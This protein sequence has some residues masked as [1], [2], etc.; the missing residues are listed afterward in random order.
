MV[1]HHKLLENILNINENVQYSHW[2]I[3]F[4]DKEI[5]KE[6]RKTQSSKIFWYCLAVLI[7]FYYL[8]GIIISFFNTFFKEFFIAVLILGILDTLATIVYFFIHKNHSRLKKLIEFSKICAIIG[9]LF[10]ITIYLQLNSGDNSFVIL[11]TIYIICLISYGFYIIFLDTSL[12]IIIIIWLVS[13]GLIITIQMLDPNLNKYKY[14]P[15]IFLSSL[16]AILG[17]IMKRNND[18]SSRTIFIQK[19]KFEKYFQYYGELISGLNGYHISFKDENI[20][21]INN[22]FKKKLK[23]F[24]LLDLDKPAEREILLTDDVLTEYQDQNKNLENELGRFSLDFFSLLNTKNKEVELDSLKSSLKQNHN[25]LEA[26]QIIQKADICS[27]HFA[28]LGKYY[29]GNN[30]HNLKHDNQKIYEVFF[31][32]LNSKILDILIYDL[33]DILKA[34]KLNHENKFKH[35]ILAKIAHEFKTPISSIISLISEV[36]ECIAGNKL[37]NILQDL[38]HVDALSSYTIFLVNDVV[39]YASQSINEVKISLDQVN[40]RSILDFSYKILRS[41]IKINDSKNKTLRTNFLYDDLVDEVFIKSDELRLKQILLNFLSNAV[42]FTKSGSITI[43][44]ILDKKDKNIKISIIDTG[45]GIRE[46][47]IE[48]LF[49]DNMINTESEYNKMGSGLGLSICRS[50]ANKLNLRIDVN[51]TFNQGSCFSVYIPYKDNAEV[52]FYN[53]AKRSSRDDSC[54]DNFGLAKESG[55]LVLKNS[56][57]KLKNSVTSKLY[58]HYKK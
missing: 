5:E 10:F 20:I 14:I 45:I 50:L 39:Q 46:D 35:K 55:E 27:D 23:D 38:N 36:K 41:L 21:S 54:I 24:F 3:N 2:F 7:F 8:T 18:V 40:L 30:Y 51:S 13:M 12:I 49:K 28:L 1:T 47:D 16:F 15:E 42:K 34:E 17:Y 29:Y 52:V 56:I 57:P 32:K 43:E 53:S 9:Q 6:Y 19:Y 44:T 48:L 25:L 11:R 22:N 31:R 26:I 4:N 37:N 58:K 33:T